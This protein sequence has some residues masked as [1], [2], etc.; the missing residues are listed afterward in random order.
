[1]KDGLRCLQLQSLRTKV[2][3]SVG[4][5]IDAMTLEESITQAVRLWQA[6]VG[7]DVWLV[8]VLVCKNVKMQEDLA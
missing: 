7:C 4:R 1:M 3:L 6:T 2:M 5:T 8:M